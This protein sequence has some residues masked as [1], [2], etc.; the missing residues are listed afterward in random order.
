MINFWPNVLVKC[1]SYQP[2]HILSI[3]IASTKGNLSV[4]GAVSVIPEYATLTFLLNK[5]APSTALH[6]DPV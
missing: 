6:Y 2:V 4:A 3:L 5:P 1:S